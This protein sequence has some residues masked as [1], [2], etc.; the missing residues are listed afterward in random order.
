MKLEEAK[1][2]VYRKESAEE[3]YNFVKDYLKKNHPEIWN[4]IFHLILRSFRKDIEE[5]KC[6]LESR[7][8]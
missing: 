4:R 6:A 7:S 5:I 1:L 8:R 2:E 3:L